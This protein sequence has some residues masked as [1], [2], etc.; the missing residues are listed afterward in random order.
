MHTTVQFHTNFSTK[1]GVTPVDLIK[2]RV[3]STQKD[4]F[5]H[6]CVTSPGFSG[7][8]FFVVS[9]KISL[10]AN[11][12]QKEKEKVMDAEPEEAMDKVL[13]GTLLA[14]HVGGYNGEFN[15]ACV[16][17]SHALQTL[18]NTSVP[19]DLYDSK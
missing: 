7:S 4:I 1:T 9:S 12:V 2:Y 8:P 13:R 3:E 10:S 5:L 6:K 15:R 11:S 19:L 18:V 17:T 14:L 16:I